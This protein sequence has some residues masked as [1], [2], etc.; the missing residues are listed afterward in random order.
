MLHVNTSL[1]A[2]PVVSNS[3]GDAV[4]VEQVCL[5]LDAIRATGKINM[6]GAGVYVE[7]EF[8]VTTKGARRLWMY[9]METFST[10]HPEG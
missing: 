3:N 9:W 10:R 7:Q 8:D 1:P 6:M 2:L 5:F 4:N